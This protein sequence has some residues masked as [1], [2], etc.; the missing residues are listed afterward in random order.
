VD[1]SGV[2]VSARM[3]S[4]VRDRTDG[5][6]AVSGTGLVDAVPQ[7]TSDFRIATS[8]SS[9]CLLRCRSDN[10]MFD[11]SIEPDTVKYVVLNDGAAFPCEF[12]FV[13][14]VGGWFCG[15]PDL[16][17][18]NPAGAEAIFEMTF[19]RLSQALSAR[20]DGQTKHKDALFVN[21]VHR[22]AVAVVVEVY[23]NK[24]LRILEEPGEH[25]E[26]DAFLLQGRGLHLQDRDKDLMQKHFNLFLQ[27]TIRKRGLRQ[28]RTYEP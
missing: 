26:D 23:L 24:G 7:V 20:N 15:S 5:S 13:S 14:G 11:V 6:V 1:G 4:L 18:T 17:G 27:A 12:L 9:P 21:V 25:A 22:L 19:A 28:T 16:P 8:A 2:S 3:S 10:P